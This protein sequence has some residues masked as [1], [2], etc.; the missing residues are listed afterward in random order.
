MATSA[1]PAPGLPVPLTPLIGREREV[2]ALLELLSETRL[3]TLT[4]AGGSGKTR[5]ALEV[6]ARR[7]AGAGGEAGTESGTQHGEPSTC[8]VELA[9]VADPAMLPQQIV[10][11]LGI[12]EELRGGGAEAALPFLSDGPL[13]LVLDNCEHLV[14]ACAD[15]AQQFLSARPRLSIL[16]T[17]R[18]A[19]GVTGE[20]AWL[21]PGLSTPHPDAD[22]EAMS[23]AEALQ[24]FVARARDV[25]RGFDL[26]P[27]NTPVVAEICRRLDGIPLAIELA[28]ARVRVLSVEQIRDR[29]NDVFS[30]LSSGGRRAVPRHR[31]LR[32][33]IDWSHE[34]LPESARRLL[35][36]LSAFRGGFTL[37]GATAVG[38]EEGEDPLDVLDRV[39]LLVDR[40]LLQATEAEGVVR[41]APLETI[42]QYGAMRL[43][44]SGESDEIRDRHARFIASEVTRAAPHMTRADRQEHVN[45][46]LADLENVR[47]ALAWTRSRAP[48]LHVDMVGCLWWFWFYTRFWKE[49]GSWIQGALAISDASVPDRS[50]GRLLLAAGALSTLATRVEEGRALLHEAGRLAAESGDEYGAAMGQNYLALSYAQVLDPRVVDHAAR[51]LAWFEEH[52]EESGHRLSLLMSALAAESTGDRPRADQLSARAIE[53]ARAFGPADLAATLQNWSLLWAYRGDYA[54]AER[55]VVASLAELRK[56]HSYMFIARGFAFMGEAAGLR[57]EPL[58]GARLLGVAHGI[59]SSIGIKPFGT[60]AARLER[61]EP[62]LREAAGPA[63]FEAAFAE[64]TKARWESVLDDLLEGWEDGGLD[65]T[66]ALAMVSPLT[67]GTEVSRSPQDEVHEPVVLH[68]PAVAPAP[69]PAPQ[70]A[71]SP[72]AGHCRIRIRTLGTFELEGDT[73]EPGAWSYA[74]PREVLVLLLLNPRGVTR[75]EIG[76]AIWPDSTSSQVKNSYH[77][78][79]HHLRKRLG[80]PS[81]VVLEGERYRLVR[82]RGIEWD[83][84]IFEEEMRQ[85]LRARDAVD[86]VRLEASLARYRGLLLDG[87]GGGR[88]LEDARD[89]YRRLHVDGLVLLARTREAAGDP[90]G[91]LD[92][93][94]R[95]VAADE[96]NEEGHRGLMRAW[97]GNGSRDRALQHFTRLRTLLRETLEADPEAS[98]VRLHQ[99]LAAGGEVQQADSPR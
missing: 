51:A 95:V 63:A 80:D 61:V 59:R 2:Q 32:A 57:G 35:M 15:A 18:E 3:L 4:G 5:L 16:A 97:A 64:G 60:D 9:A 37:D 19:L 71:I 45:R 49:A 68:A 47:E 36:R 8:W 70:P 73:V 39:A 72:A 88:W 11:A 28:A 76:D 26:T 56:E 67:A 66:L 79:L 42:R 6:L 44:E 74:R 92:A 77:V 43:A 98:T 81:L 24:L 25:S 82:E 54:R 21:V 17:S 69:A 20:R 99:E 23:R 91:A 31:T 78:T 53:V 41:Y 29:L 1:P 30:L 55:L 58:A 40:S 22:P 94:G 52:P 75:Q 38:R 50:R 7:R 89:H 84:E 27:D 83:A 12:R 62:R 93:W 65:E 34:L 14:D 10:R 87:A 48:D 90:A 46:L 86:P 96:L 33:A 85:F 13:L